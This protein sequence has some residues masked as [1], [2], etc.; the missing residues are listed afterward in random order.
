MRN[1]VVAAVQME[2]GP[3]LA[4]NLARARTLVVEA[5]ARHARLVVLPEVFAWRG[6]RDAEEGATSPI[7]GR[8]S[9]FLCGLA[10]ELGV[11]IVGGSFL[12]RSDEA[13]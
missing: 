6:P 10:A 2:S 12:E 5:A 3:D 1:P 11:T 8:V 7:P 9:D 4:A 13:R